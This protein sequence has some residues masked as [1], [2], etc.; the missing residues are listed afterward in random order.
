MALMIYLLLGLVT[1]VLFGLVFYFLDKFRPT[2]SRIDIRGLYRALSIVIFPFLF[3]LFEINVWFLPSFKSPAS[4]LADIGIGTI[5]LL[6]LMVLY[7]LFGIY[8]GKALL[9]LYIST[10]VLLSIL[11]I[12]WLYVGKYHNLSQN[13]SKLLIFNALF[14][15]GLLIS[16]NLLYIFIKPSLK[17]VAF[18]IGVG[19]LSFA[20]FFFLKSD[21]LQPVGLKELQTVGL[22]RENLPNI[23]LITIDTLRAD[24]LSCY[25]YKRIKTPNIDRLA[26]EGILFEKAISQA[27]WTT[28]SLA[29]LLTSLYPSV[30]KG[31]ERISGLR[32]K[33]FKRIGDSI[34]RLPEVLRKKGYF[35]QAILSNPHL[36]KEEGFAKGFIGFKNLA[37]RYELESFFLLRLIKHIRAHVKPHWYTP[38]DII[39]VEA[40]NWLNSNAQRRFFL[41]VHY[42]DPHVPYHP[43]ARYI[44]DLR[45]KGRFRNMRLTDF[46]NIKEGD[47]HL[48]LEDREYIEAL[49][50]GE[51]RF[52]DAEVGRLIDRLKEL[53]IYDK[54]IIIL[55]SDHGE[56]FWEHLGFEHGHTLYN[57]L[58]H[59][60]LIISL[61]NYKPI[62]GEVVNQQ[63]RLIDIFP[64][65]LELLNIDYHGVIQGKSFLPLIFHKREERIA[66]SE[67]LYRG[68]ERKSIVY[69]GF[70]YIYF[71]NL[72]REEFYDLTDDPGELSNV[73]NLHQAEAKQYRS[74]VKTIIDNNKKIAKILLKGRKGKPIE[75]NKALKERL[76][77]LGYVH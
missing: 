2:K 16:L 6:L 76:K 19:L 69:K 12:I 11:P 66:F 34:P 53:D 26:Q 70:K 61:G 13:L 57:E 48:S 30:H 45:Y 4:I 60:P 71:P 5:F 21:Y 24:H 64:S 28:P 29:S 68:E 77:A 36:T 47:Y 10:L 39:T 62:R 74:M 32:K 54:T 51:I 49:Y 52:V 37:D 22:P 43:P 75:I 25:G 73:V 8:K 63:V 72:R 59:V 31:G 58:L 67:F 7:K 55:T 33:G 40:I 27:P 15:S 65:L 56:E 18:L 41:W 9:N 46:A 50:R 44:E 42:T 3:V 1:G 38:G 17:G 20:G 14:F 35:T 23:L